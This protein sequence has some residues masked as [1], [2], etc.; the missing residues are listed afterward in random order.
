MTNYR[1]NIGGL[2]LLAFLLLA[3]AALA[4]EAPTTTPATGAAAKDLSAY[5][6]PA[7]PYEVAS[8]DALWHDRA[9]DRNVPVRIF[10]PK[11]G[12]KDPQGQAVQGPLPAVVF[13]PGLGG[14]RTV[15]GYFAKSLAAC[16]Y[17]V[18]V[19]THKG[20]DTDYFLKNGFPALWRTLGDE[21]A[22]SDRAADISFV[23][24]RMTAKDQDQELL[25]DRVDARRIGVAGHSYGAYTSLA[26]AGQTSTT[27]DGK[28][29]SYADKR[30][31]AVITMCPQSPPLFGLSERSWGKIAIPVMIM[32][33]TNDLGMKL[34]SP[35][36]TVCYKGMPAGDKYFFLLQGAGHMDFAT[37]R[38]LFSTDDKEGG[39][40][41]FH[42][43]ICQGGCAFFDAYLCGDKKARAWLKGADIAKANPGKVTLEAK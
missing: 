39:D 26:I 23:I 35:Q 31:K 22:W 20:T 1:R 19:V 11:P 17:V 36:K 6:S 9:R 8:A 14:S 29:R 7:G 21:S 33:G 2:A 24:D 38:K 40:M 30:V 27:K 34:R 41:S 3:T 10:A 37:N 4:G 5:K 25:K 28:D 13:S 12:A 15:Y 16:G 42:G 32:T 43:L 18:V